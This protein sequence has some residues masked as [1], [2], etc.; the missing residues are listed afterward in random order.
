MSKTKQNRYNQWFKTGFLLYWALVFLLFVG[1][2]FG[3]GKEYR[4]NAMVQIFVPEV[5]RMYASIP[6]TKLE[7]TYTF[8]H[9]GQAVDTVI[10][11]QYY[12]QQLADDFP[13][14]IA[15]RHS[16][17][18]YLHYFFYSTTGVVNAWNKYEWDVIEGRAEAGE[19]DWKSVDIPI[20]N[21][22]NFAD[23]YYR[24]GHVRQPADS[25]T[26]EINRIY[27][28][29]E[30]RYMWLRKPGDSIFYHSGRKLRVDVD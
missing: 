20:K 15:M 23:H 28:I 5:F 8:Y 11:D 17:R 16:L 26:L 27:N 13:S 10:G 1:D 9:H 18:M 19:F 25:F 4:N 30:P 21:Y 29:I 14:P 12:Q 6:K 24:N 7:K 22:E 2:H 3:V